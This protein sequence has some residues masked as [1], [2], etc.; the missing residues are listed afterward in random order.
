LSLTDALQSADSAVSTLLNEIGVSVDNSPLPNA[1]DDVVN[2]DAFWH[3]KANNGRC[4]VDLQNDV[5]T[6]DIDQSRREGFHAVEHLKRY[7]TLGM[8]TDQGKT[9][10]VLGLAIM[11]E[12]AGQ[13]IPDT[14]TTIFRPPYTPVAISAFA[15]RSTGKNFRPTRKTPSHQWAEEQN[16]VFVEVGAWLR[17]QWYPQ[18]GESHWRESVDREVLQTR[19]SV[20]VCDVTTLGKIDIQGCLCEHSGHPRCRKST[21]RPYAS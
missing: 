21:L 9:S 3:V 2:I 7:T 10:N 11:A 16:A 6:K 18:P 8:A 19:N 4:W 1:S 15:G 5:T 14:G 20:G 12:L 17:A 13:S